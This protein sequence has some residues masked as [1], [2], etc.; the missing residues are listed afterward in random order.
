MDIAGREALV[1]GA[2]GGLGQAIARALSQR[3]ARLILTGRRTTVLEPLARELDAEMITAD[4][5][6]RQS[7]EALSARAAQVDILIANAALPASGATEDFTVEEIDRALDVNLRAPILLARAAV[8]TMR[9]RGEGHLVFISSMSG[10]V[11]LAGAS[12]YSATKFGLRGFALALRDELHGTGVGASVVYPGFVR[13]AGMFADAGVE[14]PPFVG[15]S[16]P[17]EVGSAVVRAIERNRG[18]VTVAPLPMR[19]GS[20]VARIAPDFGAAVSRRL[21]GERIVEGMVEGQR[22]KR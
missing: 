13:E 17:E 10:R 4:L 3:G 9:R 2:T 7:L 6:D 14:L 5:A 11:A 21:G 18:E 8:A 15:T 12:L 1:T 16:A 20:V 19:L 22:V